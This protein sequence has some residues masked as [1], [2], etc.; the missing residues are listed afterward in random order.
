VVTASLNYT[1]DDEDHL[2]AS[3][4]GTSYIYD[5]AGQ[6]AVVSSNGAPLEYYYFGGQ[7][8]AT[9]D[10]RR[11]TGRT[12]CMPTVSDLPRLRRTER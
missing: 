7:L 5:A 10:L 12:C 11:I 2:T 4:D 9:Y 3:S 6:R 1:Y 8:M